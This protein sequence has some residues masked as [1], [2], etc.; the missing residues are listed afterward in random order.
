MLIHRFMPDITGVIERRILVN[1]R[2]D[3]D[4]M[5]QMLPEPFEPHLVGGSAIAGI[6]LIQLRVRP[7]WAPNWSGVR[8]HNGAHRVAVLMPDGSPAVYIPR[9]DTDA[10]LNVAVGGRLFPGEHHLARFD[11]D[12]RGDTVALTLTSRDDATR[13]SVDT[14]VADDLPVDSIFDDVAHVSEFFEHGSL[15]YS[16]TKDDHRY[17]GIELDALN[18]S[19]TPLHVSSASSTFFEDPTQ[20]PA[21]SVQLDNA[22]LMRNIHHTWRA[23][24]P[25]TI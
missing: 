8:S 7:S 15:G 21:G 14:A 18:W 23:Q 12:D 20:F 13:L 6:C 24:P 11:V 25:L 4:V 9:R 1:Y 19:V 5:A 2:V 10:R 22:L 16:D 3:P 17:D